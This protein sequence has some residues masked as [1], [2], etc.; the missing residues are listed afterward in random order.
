VNPNTD[1]L[2][3]IRANLNKYGI[4]W[5]NKGRVSED[6][7]F[8]IFGKPNNGKQIGIYNRTSTIIRLEKYDQKMEGVVIREK[9]AI[10]HAAEAEFSNFKKERGVCVKVE[11]TIALQKLLDWYFGL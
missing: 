2:P 8:L 3:Y 1:A 11:N 7:K 10:S 6:F 5:I 9:C 4:E